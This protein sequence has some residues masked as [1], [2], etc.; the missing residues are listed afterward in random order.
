METNIKLSMQLSMQSGGSCTVVTP[1][2]WEREGGLAHGGGR[3]G[4][5]DGGGRWG[6]DDGC[7]RSSQG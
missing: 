7:R 2:R 5:D 1:C 4:G 6:G 3:W